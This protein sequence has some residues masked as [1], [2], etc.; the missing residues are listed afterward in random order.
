MYGNKQKRIGRFMPTH[1]SVRIIGDIHGEFATYNLMRG[2]G[3]SIQI[4]D[5][6]AGFSPYEELPK[7]SEHHRMIRGNHDNPAVIK[8]LPGY[9]PDGHHEG[10]WFFVGGAWSID[11]AYRTEGVSWW[12]DEELSVGELYDIYDKYVMAKPR[13]MITHDGPSS[14]TNEMIISKG[15]SISG[16]QIPTRTGQALDAMF[17]AHK[18][19]YWFFGHYHVNVEENI[20]GTYFR[21]VASNDFIDF[22]LR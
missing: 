3:P 22:V 2:F 16:K 8:N 21:C 18:P 6:G 20:M 4:G 1:G 9:I 10:D 15:L 11:W 17:Q 5:F 14:V 12:P 13:V 19:E 7:T